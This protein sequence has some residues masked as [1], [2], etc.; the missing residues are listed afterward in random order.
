M[1]RC[2]G[3]SGLLSVRGALSA[4]GSGSSVPTGEDGAD[5]SP[6]PAAEELGEP[7][8]PQRCCESAPHALLPALFP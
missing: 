6:D 5:P 7:A 8:D 2:L 3:G 4:G 1:S